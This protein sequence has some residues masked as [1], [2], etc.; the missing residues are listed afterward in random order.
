MGRSSREDNVEYTEAIDETYQEEQ[1][2]LLSS[3]KPKEWFGK[4]WETI[5]SPMKTFTWFSFSTFLIVIILGTFMVT[6]LV[7]Y[8]YLPTNYNEQFNKIEKISQ[9]KKTYE[10]F[11]AATKEEILVSWIDLF[12]N[13]DYVP[14]GDPKY[15]KYDC[16]GALNAVFK[17]WGANTPI[18][19]V[20][21]IVKR[22]DNLAER[23]GL[24]IRNSY[25]DVQPKDII[26]IQTKKND[27]SHVGMVWN[28]NNGYVQYVDVNAKVQTIGFNEFKFGDWHIYKI[29]EV[30]YSLWVGDLLKNLQ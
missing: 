28:T 21:T 14:N 2:A 17:Y 7:S 22:C 15:N 20:A 13:S 1:K 29:Y 4:I 25:G 24:N 6:K 10:T 11:R 5:H 18:E 16:V 30:S 19:N 3:F 27:P 26:I 12:S 8:T 23:G 9:L